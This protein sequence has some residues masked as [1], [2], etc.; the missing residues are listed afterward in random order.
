MLS[1]NYST[2]CADL[3]ERLGVNR[4]FD[5]V[6]RDL[7]IGS[8]RA[9]L[10][11]VDG[12]ADDTTAE[13]I[14]AFLLS[15]PADPPISEKTAQDFAARYISFDEVAYSP[16]P[17]QLITDVLV[18]KL[19]LLVEGIPDGITIDAKHYPSRS[20]EEPGDSRVL[21]GA[22]DGFVEV[23][24][25]NTALLRRRIRDPRFTVEN[26]KL[27]DKSKTDVVICFMD[28]LADP[29]LL[30][31]LREKLRKV[32]ARS[33]S[34]GQESV[35]EAM[36]KGQWYDPLPRVRYTER[37]DVAAACVL[38]GNII[39]IV[40]N[41]PSVMLLPTYFLD[42]LQEANDFYFPP[43]VGSY[44]RLLRT[45]IM[46][47]SLVITPI[48]LLLEE[49][50][51][52]IPEAFSFLA[53]EGDCAVP[54]FFQLIIVELIIDVLKL[55]SLNTP[56][57]LSNS[58]STLGA[59]VLGDFAVQARWLVPE[60]LIYMAFVAIAGFAQ[61]SYELAYSMKLS[62]VLLLLLAELFSWWGFGAGVLI[63]FTVI[64]TTRPIIG[65]SYLFGGRHKPTVLVR[66]P[67]N[68]N[69]T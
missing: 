67:I 36:R 27:G 58:F 3:D 29:E 50:P 54:V 55:A 60:V 53:I 44:L 15:V 59:L 6:G 22:H 52:S 28:G 68:K 19:L 18:G 42:F 45:I 2:D 17:S 31:E 24:L 46:L 35:T 66:H 32:N 16:D 8:R 40:D 47:L 30:E 61:P 43:I 62:R 39:V 4:N 21:R 13:R 9:R 69:N 37:P 41:S 63:I 48:W 10:W 5:I 65:K 11:F 56:D 51:E 25:H 14:I 49:T 20:V 33:F 34:M 38:E 7:I 12:Y 26:H 64:A 23:L 57:V 1:G